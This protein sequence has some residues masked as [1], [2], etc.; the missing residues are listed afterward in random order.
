M[1]VREREMEKS[2]SLIFDY[3]YWE[4]S[5]TFSPI[6]ININSG[7]LHANVTSVFSKESVSRNL[8]YS[9]YKKV[10]LRNCKIQLPLLTSA[11]YSPFNF[12]SMDVSIWFIIPSVRPYAPAEY[13]LRLVSRFLPCCKHQEARELYFHAETFPTI[14]DQDV[15]NLSLNSCAR[16]RVNV[17]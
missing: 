1:C 13:C 6:W 16:R 7:K 15:L 12:K 8:D 10:Y 4:Y 9:L 3:V 5:C 17:R 11:I 2:E 14:T